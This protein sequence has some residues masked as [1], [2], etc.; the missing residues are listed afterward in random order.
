[1]TTQDA[2][3]DEAAY[4]IRLFLGALH[5]EVQL[6]QPLDAPAS[7]RWFNALHAFARAHHLLTDEADG[8]IL[9]CGAGKAARLASGHIVHPEVMPSM[10]RRLV[11]W[12]DA[13]DAVH[14]MR[15]WCWRDGRGYRIAVCGGPHG[16]A[17]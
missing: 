17:G 6:R 15:F 1:M 2:A 5:I 10:G 16:C 14:R 12:I 4:P 9:V 3:L 8:V 7:R 13:H 11:L